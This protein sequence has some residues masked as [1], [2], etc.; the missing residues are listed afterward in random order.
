MGGWPTACAM[1]ALA[2]CSFEHGVAPDELGSD[3]GYQDAVGTG[4]DGAIGSSC[5]GPA[6]GAWRVCLGSVPTG[7]VMLPPTLDTTTSMLCLQAQPAEW[8]TSGQPPACFVVGDAIQTSKTVVT[9]SR[10]LVLLSSG[11][12]TI[13][14]LDLASH[15]DS[16]A[17]GPG[18]DPSVCKPFAANPQTGDGNG[19][20]A[21]GSFM[22]KGGDGGDGHDGDEKGGR[23]ATADGTAPAVLRGGCRGQKGGGFSGGAGGHGGGAAYL[24]AATSIMVTG[25]IN[26]SGAGGSAGNNNKPGGGGAGSG[27]MIVLYAPLIGVT[28]TVFANGGG[29]GGGGD[30]DGSPG[31]DP[32]FAGVTAGG[33]SPAGGDGYALS[34]NATSGGRDKDGGGGGGGG[35]GYIRSNL[36]IGATSPAAD[37]VP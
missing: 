5:Y 6:A 15:A 7:G 34:V 16:S 3:G 27:G 35:A 17:T 1:L 9:G 12:I 25:T 33:G 36:T 32:L 13:G 20:G 24:V 4:L 22:T 8:T 14:S 11:T 18:A 28:G 23:A 10:P 29:G 19:G 30:G 31:D 21:A 2:G 37:I 26:A